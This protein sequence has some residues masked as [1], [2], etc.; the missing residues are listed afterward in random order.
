MTTFVLGLSKEIIKALKENG[1]ES[2]FPIKQ[3]AIPPILKGGYWQN[4]CFFPSHVKKSQSHGSYWVTHT[5]SYKGDN[6]FSRYTG[7]RTASIYGGQSTGIQYDQL[8]EVCK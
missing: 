8:R 5:C 4:C 2:P 1:F 7:I 6:R 3:A